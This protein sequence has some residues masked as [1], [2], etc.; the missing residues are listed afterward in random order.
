MQPTNP[1]LPTSVPTDRP[2]TSKT[3]VVNNNN[4]EDDESSNNNGQDEYTGLSSYEIARLEKIA[5]NEDKLKSLGLLG[6]NRDV[7]M[8]ASEQKNKRKRPPKKKGEILPTR[9]SKD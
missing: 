7:M 6:N 5:R 2:L 3:T 4:N 8:A 1:S 9:K